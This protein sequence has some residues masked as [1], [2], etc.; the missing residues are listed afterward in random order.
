MPFALIVI[1]SIKHLPNL[2][3]AKQSL[4]G[5]GCA[6]GVAGIVHRAR[7]EPRQKANDFRLS[8]LSSAFLQRWRL[9]N[10]P[11]RASLSPSLYGKRMPPGRW[12]G[13][14]VWNLRGAIQSH[15]QGQY[16]TPLT[17]VD[18]RGEFKPEAIIL[19]AGVN[20]MDCVIGLR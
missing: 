13:A 7:P 14:N 9:A 4:P 19:N 6:S 2:F 11:M 10:P 5:A 16:T 17:Q 8:E 15:C 1:M 12:P 3:T 18:T 20:Q